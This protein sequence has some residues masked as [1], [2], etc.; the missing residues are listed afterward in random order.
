MPHPQPT[1]LS[2]IIPVFNERST[3]GIL[4]DRVWDQSLPH[5]LS[6]ELVIVESN[7][8]DGTRAE[9]QKWCQTR[10]AEASPLAT[11]KLILQPGPRGKGNAVREGLAQTT[12]DIV[13]I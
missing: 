8:T 7:S 1:R 3:V 13:L 11:V 6:K 5:N 4:L 9:V 12:G 10:Q 2:I